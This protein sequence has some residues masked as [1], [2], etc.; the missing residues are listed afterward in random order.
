MKKVDFDYTNIFAVTRADKS[1]AMFTVTCDYSDKV[2]WNGSYEAYAV[3]LVNQVIKDTDWLDGWTSVTVI[4][5][6]LEEKLGDFELHRV[7]IIKA[8][9]GEPIADFEQV[10]LI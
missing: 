7:Y 2:A 5:P 9:N 8:D 6:N 4:S 1:M 3:D 10:E